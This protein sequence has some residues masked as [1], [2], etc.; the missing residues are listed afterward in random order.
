MPLY[1]NMMRIMSSFFLCLV[2]FLQDKS[3]D[4]PAEVSN[5]QDKIKPEHWQC[6]RRGLAIS[7]VGDVN[8]MVDIWWVVM[9]IDA[10]NASSLFVDGRHACLSI[11]AAVEEILKK[12]SV[13]QPGVIREAGRREGGWRQEA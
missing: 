7:L 6:P 8:D 1:E 13:T 5:S 11:S 9:V 2:F 3:D 10:V 4:I 12:S